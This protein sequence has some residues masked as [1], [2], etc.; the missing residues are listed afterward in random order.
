[1]AGTIDRFT[2]RVVQ[3]PLKEPIPHPFMGARTQFATLILEVHTTDGVTGLGFATMESLRMVRAVEEIVRGLEPGLRGLD[4]ARRAFVFD[5]MWNLRVDL[6]HDGASNIAL[7]AID[8]AIWDICGK[9]SDTPLWQ[10]LGGYRDKVPAYASGTL[11]RHHDNDRL[12]RDAA[13]LVKQ[14][15]KAMK[16]RLGTTRPFAD[17]ALRAKL[18]REAAG[19]DTTL[20]VD[21]LWALSPMQGVKMAEM[22]GELEYGWLEEPVREGDFAGLA[23]VRATRALPIAAGERISR[24]QMLAELIPCIDH[25]ILDMIHLGGITPCLRAA[26]ALETVNLPISSHSYSFVNM[27]VIAALRTGAWVEHMDWWD[28]LFVDPPQVVAGLITLPT[29]P[30]LGLAL[31]EKAIARRAVN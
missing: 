15:F 29:A 23:H 26:A 27:H 9:R 20:L 1:M 28:E 12:Q 25:G 6:L 5:R 30:G 31:D 16:L 21:A 11:W 14:G 18:V 10:M 4:P 3:I 7:A 17:E 19:R 22:L 2:T 13:A 8:T 24:V